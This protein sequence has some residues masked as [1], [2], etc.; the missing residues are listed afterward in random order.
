MSGF[1]EVRRA[2]VDAAVLRNRQ[3]LISGTDDG[4]SLS[5]P[6]LAR[7][8]V[9]LLGRLEGGAGE[10][11]RFDDEVAEH[12]RYAREDETRRRL[13]RAIDEHIERS[14]TDAAAAESDP[15][16]APIDGIGRDAPGAL[17]LD[18]EGVGTVIWCTGMRPRLDAV[19]IP[20]LADGGAIPHTS[21]VTAVPGLYVLGAPWLRL[22]KSGIIWGATADAEQ[23]AEAIA[24][25]RRA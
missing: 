2:D 17:R 24:A 5:L 1:Y 3:P 11:V 25:G 7:R 4:H 22:R 21:G 13:L 16:C 8:G 6:S 23:I 18:R 19:A 15:S 20:G 10:D 14:G 12:A 9:E